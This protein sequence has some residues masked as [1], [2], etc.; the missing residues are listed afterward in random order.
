MSCLF[1]PRF[2]YLLKLGLQLLCR[3]PNGQSRVDN[4]ETLATLGIGRIQG[5]ENGQSRV[6]NPA[7]LATLGTGR[8]QTQPNGQFHNVASVAG[9]STL[10][11][12]FCFV[13]IRSVH[14]F[15]SVTGLSTLDCPFCF[16]CIRSVHNIQ[17]KQNGQSRVDNPATLATL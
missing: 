1:P 12:P 5:K 8:I 10:D 3:K 13:C 14:N 9:L 11:C 4:P 6:D 17:T 2:D 15:A 16:V 7:T